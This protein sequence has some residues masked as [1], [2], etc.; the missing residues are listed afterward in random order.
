M[1]KGKPLKYEGGEPLVRLCWKV[2]QQ[3]EVPQLL[4]TVI[5]SRYHAYIPSI[6]PAYIPSRYHVYI[7]SRFCFR[8]L[9]NLQQILCSKRLMFWILAL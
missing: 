4:F 1:Y 6:Y 3:F 9:Y 5:P 8:I 7:P 2:D